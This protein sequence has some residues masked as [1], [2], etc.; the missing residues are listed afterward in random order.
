MLDRP[1]PGAL[2]A[3]A[4]SLGSPHSPGSTVELIVQHLLGRS[5]VII[6]D[7]CEH[8]IERAATLADTL[9]GA[10]PGVRLIATSR[11]PLGV[12][13]EVLLPVAG[14]A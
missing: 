11:Q 10:L 2:G 13:G 7:N 14:L 8:V 1:W 12:P 9:V 6:L 5:P 4:S 3:A